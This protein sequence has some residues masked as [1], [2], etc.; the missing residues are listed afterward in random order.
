M[1]VYTAKSKQKIFVHVALMT[2]G[3]SNENS[4][5]LSP[6]TVSQLSY[7]MASRLLNTW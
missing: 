7:H 4:T 5:M 3:K 1:R 2:P 6:R